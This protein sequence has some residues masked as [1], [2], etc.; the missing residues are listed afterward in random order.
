MF[1]HSRTSRTSPSSTQ[2]RCRRVTCAEFGA[3]DALAVAFQNGFKIGAIAPGKFIG[4][5]VGNRGIK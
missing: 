5:E 1:N 3:H 4:E 2:S